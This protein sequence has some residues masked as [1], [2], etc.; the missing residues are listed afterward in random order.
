M[1]LQRARR[2][3]VAGILDRDDR[4]SSIK[5]AGEQRNR[6]LRPADDDDVVGVAHHNRAAARGIR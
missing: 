2:E 5:H 1:R 3:L 4:P 6:L